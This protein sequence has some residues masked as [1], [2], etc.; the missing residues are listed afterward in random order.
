MTHFE[1]DLPSV[2]KFMLIVTRVGTMTVFAPFF[3]TTAFPAPV[4]VSL[5]LFV[6]LVL[7]PVV[8]APVLPMP[9]P[10]IGWGFLL[11]QEGLIGLGVGFVVRLVF[12]GVQL[13]GQLIGFQIG[14]A[15]VNIIDPQTAVS[16]TTLTVFLNFIAVIIFLL[17]N[18]HHFIIAALVGSYA[19]LPPMHA[20]FGG[21]VFEVLVRATG[22]VWVS[23]LQMAAP[24]LFLI[25]LLDVVIGIIGR[26]APQIPILIIAMPLKIIVGLLAIGIGLTYFGQAVHHFVDLFQNDALSFLKAVARG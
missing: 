9:M 11:L 2:V 1:I 16:S 8:P 22:A 5:V 14:F 23:G 26:V 10:L 19:Y 17:M 15:M 24:M 7:F 13:A 21:N 4:R 20:G 3:S 18:G 6:G 25:V 12:A